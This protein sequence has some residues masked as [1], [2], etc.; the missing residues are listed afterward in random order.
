MPPDEQIKPLVERA[1][2][3]DRDALA[4]LFDLFYDGVYR[5]AYVRLG[6]AADAEEAAQET[7]VQMVKSIRRFRWQGAEF[8][9]WLFRIA[10]NVVAGEQRRR[11]RRRE[12]LRDAVETS[13]VAASAEDIAVSR[14]GIAQMRE[15]LA[16]LSEEQRRVLELRFTSGLSSDEI[17][18]VLGK[19]AGAVRIQQMR[20]LQSLRDRLEVTR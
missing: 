9:A 8:A 10:R 15:L 11:F 17:A 6:S 19:S 16:V 13:D 4:A 1:Q 18:T 7:F 20:A 2:K 3:G 12:D 14:E 5:F